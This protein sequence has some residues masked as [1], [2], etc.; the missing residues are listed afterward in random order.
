MGKSCENYNMSDT[1]LATSLLEEAAKSNKTLSS[2][3]KRNG[4]KGGN[5]VQFPVLPSFPNA[6]SGIKELTEFPLAMMLYGI[7]KATANR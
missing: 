6:C 4:L 7:S 2:F 3:L 5:Y 1:S